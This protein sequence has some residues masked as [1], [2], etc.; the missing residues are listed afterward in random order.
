[1]DVI[2]ATMPALG[3][4]NPLRPIARALVRRGHRVRWWTDR[5]FA[6]IVAGTGADFVP[7]TDAVGMP[8]IDGLAWQPERAALSGLDRIRW[9]IENVFV[10]PIPGQVAE[11]R[12]LLAAHPAQ[13]IVS[14]AGLMGAGPLYELGG[15]AWASV[16]TTPLALPGRDTAP[17]GA[18]RPPSRSVAGR[19][20]NQVLCQLQDRVVLRG[21]GAA[22]N[23]IRAE[24]GLPRTRTPVMSTGFSPLL[25]LQMGV[26]EFEYPR[27]DLP[28]QVHF[29]GVL[30]DSTS[31]VPT[32]EWWPEVAGSTRPVVHVTQG[33]V[34]DAELDDLVLPTL[35]ALADL[36]VLVLATT[37]RADPASLG[38]LPANARAARMLP[39]PLLLPRCAV[40]VTNGGYGGV[41]QALAHGV[42][43]VVAG[44]SEDK[45]EVAARVAWTG[46]GVDLGGHR[47]CEADIRAA[48]RAVLAEPSYRRHAHRL[49]EAYRRTDAATR[50]AELL[51]QLATSGRPVSRGAEPTPAYGKRAW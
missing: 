5:S 33:T 27:S 48:V 3:H 38:P 25:H 20:R 16:G 24:L 46:A 30:A 50:S 18:A 47:P 39:Y 13:L 31:P 15:P 7:M 34:A 28:A 6:E 41:Q 12:A 32:P 2:I 36:D 37:G 4:L 8:R 40:M 22:V 51:E 29:V 44:G 10:N 21:V 26:A 19:L 17:F 9:D 43:L 42:P 1:M 45:P 49:R 11:L 14:D 23:R 35:R